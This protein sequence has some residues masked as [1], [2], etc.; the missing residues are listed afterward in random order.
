MRCPDAISKVGGTIVVIVGCLLVGTP[1]RAQNAPPPGDI[2]VQAD[3]I[4]CW[5]RTST[6]AVRVGEAFSTVLT[7]AV[8]ENES[9][10]VVPDERELDPSAMQLP[11]FETVG[12]T[13]ATDL[14]SGQRRFFQYQYTL[15]LMSESMFNRDAVLEGVEIPY[16][17]QTR[18]EGQAWS[19]G[20]QYTY[21]LPNL[22]VR[23]LSLVPQDASDIRDA[24][25]DTFLDIE[26]GAF[27]ADVLAVISGMLFTFGALMLV[28]G[29]VRVVGRRRVGVRT[30]TGLLSPRATLGSVARELAAVRREREAH[31]W[32]SELAGRAL[33]ACRVAGTYAIGS[34]VSQVPGAADGDGAEGKLLLRAGWLGR[35]AVTVSGWVTPAAVAHKVAQ[36][37]AASANGSTRDAARI[38]RL[39]ALQ[40][41]LLHFTAARY[42][43]EE[44]LADD[45]LDEALAACASLTRDLK[46]EQAWLA[47]RM[48]FLGHR[49]AEVGQRA[50]P[51]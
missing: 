9:S 47:M 10:K 6:G 46:L 38:Q 21:T 41:A 16:R 49:P 12:G 29:G 43:R 15:R 51:R 39:E 42:G 4:R 31:G 50:W 35:T 1:S 20:R 33:A 40:T 37:A 45:V 23:V 14:R 34:R 7:C 18:V 28:L 25:R 48:S 26:A 5:W 44:T 13:H 36:L 19:E 17:I 27:R 2:V 22:S 11:P 24:A 30:A 8:I 3:P 32:N